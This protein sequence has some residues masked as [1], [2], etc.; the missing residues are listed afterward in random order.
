MSKRLVYDADF[1]PIPEVLFNMTFKNLQQIRAGMLMQAHKVNLSVV[2][3]GVEINDEQVAAKE[4]SHL[5]PVRVYKPTKIS[6][7]TAALIYVHGGGFVTGSVELTHS[8]CV[9]LARELQAI[10]ISVDYRLAPET[11][12][13]GPLEDC[14]QV[15]EWAVLNNELLMIDPSRLAVM[16]ESAGANLVAALTLA[17]RDNASAVKPCFQFLGVPVLDDRMLSQSMRDFDN[18]PLLSSKNTAEAWDLYLGDLKRGEAEIPFYAAPARAINLESLPPT[19]ISVMEFDP[20]R[21]EGLAYA[22]RLLQAGVATEVHC[23]PGAFHGSRLYFPDAEV[24]KRERTE[25]IYILRRA[26]QCG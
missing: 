25:M 5:I 12:Y 6:S 1:Y 2:T 20:L 4:Q 15:F 13:P 26:L 14:L 18:T 11:P 9:D 3:E 24:S 7:A 8:L 22:Q 19:Y 10:I 21:D 16:G 23:Y 17:L